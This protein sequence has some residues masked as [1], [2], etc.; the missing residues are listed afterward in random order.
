MEGKCEMEAG[1]MCILK[2]V[3]S[4][5]VRWRLDLPRGE[6][7]GVVKQRH[8]GVQSTSRSAICSMYSNQYY[9]RMQN[10]VNGATFSGPAA[11]SHAKVRPLGRPHL[12][13]CFTSANGEKRCDKWSKVYRYTSLGDSANIFISEQVYIP[14]L[15]VDPLRDILVS[16]IVY[17]NQ[18]KRHTTSLS[19]PFPSMLPSP[20]GT[21]TSPLTS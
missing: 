14:K 2:M 5:R 6:M 13:A 4:L 17:S 21:L 16:M 7:F 12:W 15:L 19:G 1:G 10:V 18:N 9:S 20:T 3:S 11:M 8:G